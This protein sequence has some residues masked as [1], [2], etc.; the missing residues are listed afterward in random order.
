MCRKD[1]EF[2]IRNMNIDEVVSDLL[3]NRRSDL[4]PTLLVEVARRCGMDIR[5][6]LPDGSEVNADGK[7]EAVCI[8]V[9]DK[10]L[11]TVQYPETE[12]DYDYLHWTD[13]FR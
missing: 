5:Y 9:T 8:T 11:V 4:C 1:S 2:S 7:Y 6:V 13:A 10:V 3:E 12:M